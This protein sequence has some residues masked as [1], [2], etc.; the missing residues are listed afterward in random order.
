M[1]RNNPQKA[2]VGNYC[3]ISDDVELGEDVVICGFV[4]LY[5]CRIGKGSHI[6]TFV[7]IQ[8]GVVVGKGVRIQS[9]S[10]ICSGVQVEDDVFIGHNVTFVNDRY[11]TS[12]KAAKNRWTLESTKIQRGASIGSGAVILCGVEIGQGAVVGA[13]SV[14]NKNI[15]PH[16]IVAGVPAQ[17][18]KLISPDDRWM[19][20]E[21]K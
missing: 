10:F 2:K 15:P 20:G 18:V 7:E 6:G 14:V 9:H 4:N 8:K 13:G 3:T 16:T 5:G 17:F 1:N 12:L 19:G 21:K 11:P